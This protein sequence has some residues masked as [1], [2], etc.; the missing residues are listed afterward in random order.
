MT[1]LFEDFSEPVRLNLWDFGGQ[2]VYHGSHSL[3]LQGQAVFLILWTPTL[4]AG[5]DSERDLRFRHRPLSYWLDYLRA[6]AGTDASVLIVQS[7]CDSARDR[8]SHPPVKV[9]DFFFL[10]WLEVSAKTGLGLNLV[11]AALEESVRD[12]FERCPSPPIGAGRI[13]VRDRLRQLLEEDQKLEPAKQRHRLLERAEFDH[14]CDEVGGVSDKEALLDFLHHNGAVFYRPG[15]FSDR[16]I[17]DQNWALEAIYAL[18]DRKKILPLLRGYGRF[19]RADLEA[20]IWSG[21]TPEEQKV[22]LGMMESC[23][24]CFRVRELPQQEQLPWWDKEWEYIAPELLPTWSEAQKSLLTGRIP[25]GL[26][27]AE[28][29]ARYAFLHEGVLRGY[30]S[31]I[32]LQAGDSAL[33]WKYGCWAYEETTDSRVL[34]ESQWQDA[35]SEAGG[36]SIR[37]RAWGENAETL[38]DPLLETLQKL[39][40]GQ[41]P[42]IKRT[43]TIALRG[44]ARAS[45]SITARLHSGPP[46]AGPSEIVRQD[47]SKQLDRPTQIKLEDL[48]FARDPQSAGLTTAANTSHTDYWAPV[49][50]APQAPTS[51]KTSIQEVVLLIHG[52]RD[53]AEWQDMVA[54]VLSE[55]QNIEVCPLKYGRFDAFRFWFP[56]WTR[57][58]PVKNLLWRVRAAIKQYSPAKL[59]VVAHSFGTYAIGKILRENP[60]IRL[61]RLILCG[62]ILPSNFH[63]DQIQHN[64]EPPIIN[65]CGIK[66]IWPVLAHSTT[67]GYGPSGRFGFGTPGVRDRYHDFGHGGFFQEKFV[68]DFWLPWFR[69]GTFVKSKAPPPSGA[70]WHLLTIFQIKW[71]AFLL[72]VLGISWLALTNVPKGGDKSDAFRSTP[73]PTPIPQPTTTATNVK[74]VLS[75]ERTV[76]A[77]TMKA[78]GSKTQ[79]D[80]REDNYHIEAFSAWGQ[81]DG[82]TKEDTLSPP[83]GY[84]LVDFRYRYHV[85]LGPSD[86]VHTVERVN[87]GVRYRLTAMHGPWH[88]R[89]R[90]LTNLDITLISETVNVVPSEGPVVSLIQ[91][92][93]VVKRG[94]SVKIVDFP[95]V[96]KGDVQTVD[97]Y[98]LTIKVRNPNGEI[99]DGAWTFRPSADGTSEEYNGV[100]I[101]RSGDSI[102]V[103]F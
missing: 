24:I 74:V 87:N 29:E 2:E 58:A 68:S 36:G 28:A 64:V 86:R 100:R 80:R 78:V 83:Q 76:V 42:E 97:S 71:L 57:E 75:D 30:L 51:P 39:P 79:I 8:A 48:I 69:S 45:A 31:K 3:F 6:F 56:L 46:V 11:K 65:D 66:D 41:S 81:D 40:V 93:V 63:W 103:D 101:A 70:H 15:L 62:A 17:L 73:T 89:E 53:F 98:V 61:H 77:I 23:G 27:M 38:I 95:N 59:S 16:I 26:P 90:N 22:F 55:I 33:Y 102:F 99:S 14:L 60:D 19:N 92:P 1:L 25:M 47:T 20:L 9:D 67:F 7:Q 88:N 32:G 37:L 96:A 10:R 4:E 72:C 94:Q 35:E 21:Y 82:V 52:I 54:T 18:F 44:T 85:T 84:R 5:S 34:I 50:D 49:R 13:K 12:C 43:K 91:T